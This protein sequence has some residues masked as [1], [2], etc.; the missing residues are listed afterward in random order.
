MM[1]T[2]RRLEPQTV[3][4]YAMPAAPLESLMTIMGYVLAKGIPF[5]L[6]TYVARELQQGNCFSMLEY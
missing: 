5:P 3:P 2:L 1:F 4:K 6:F